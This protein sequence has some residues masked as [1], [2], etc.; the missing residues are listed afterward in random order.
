MIQVGGDT[1]WPPDNKVRSHSGDIVA[2][3]R[4]DGV[5][6]RPLA[7]EA[8]NAEPGLSC[9]AVPQ[10]QAVSIFSAAACGLYGMTDIVLEGNG[11]DGSGTFMLASNRVSVFILARSAAMLEVL[12]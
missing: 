12:P 8:R 5:Y 2:Y 9:D 4:K 3:L 10:E 7:A 6:A 1:Y 11:S